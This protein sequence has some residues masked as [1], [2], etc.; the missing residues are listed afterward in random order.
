VELTRRESEILRLLNSGMSTDEVGKLL[1]L[2]PVTIRR[3]VSAAVARL[4]V[5]DRAAALQAI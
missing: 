5:A 3:H 2:S 4:G 1:S